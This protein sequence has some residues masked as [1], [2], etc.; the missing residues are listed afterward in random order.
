MTGSDIKM[1][2][3]RKNFLKAESPSILV[4][5]TSPVPGSVQSSGIDNTGTDQ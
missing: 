4:Q 1:R 3:T 5:M 2:I